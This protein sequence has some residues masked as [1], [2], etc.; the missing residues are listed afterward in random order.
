MRKAKFYESI[1]DFLLAKAGNWLLFDDDIVVVHDGNTT[2]HSAIENGRRADKIDF[3]LEPGPIYLG[4]QE[5]RFGFGV[6]NAKKVH[7]LSWE[8]GESLIAWFW[9]IIV[10]NPTAG[11]FSDPE[12]TL[13][14]NYE[15]VVGTRYNDVLNLWGL[16]PGGA[17]NAAQE[18]RF[19]A[20]QAIAVPLGG[21]PAE[22][23]AM[24]DALMETARQVPQNQQ[25]VV[26]ESGDGNDIVVGTRTGT[27]RIYGGN[28]NDYL[29]AG[30]FTSELYGGPGT[31]YLEGGGFKSQLYGGGGADIFELSSHTFIMDA[32]TD[33]FVTWGG[34]RV[35]GGVQQTWMEAGWAYW[36]P[37]SGLLSGAT[38]PFLGIWGS[39]SVLV[40]IAAA[41][42]FRFALT[43]SNQLVIQYGRGRTGQAVIENYQ[44]NLDTGAAS[45]HVVV[46]AQEI[47]PGRA[48]L[49]DFTRYI[50]LALKAGFGVGL[51]KADPLVVDLDGDGVELVGRGAGVYFDFDRD[52]FAERAAWVHKDDGLLVR[53]R[54]GNGRVDDIGDLFGNANQ[55][56]FTALAA[57]DANHDGRIDRN[58]AAFST[59]RI[60][61]DADQDGV[62]D[63]GELLT[64][65]QAGIE[66]ISLTK[67]A[68]ADAEI[69]GNTVRA[70]ATVTRTDGGV[71]TIADVQ[72]EI[73]QTDSRYLGD[74]TLSPAA[75][76]LPNLKGYGDVADLAVAMM[77]AAVLRQMVATFAALPE[78]AKWGGLKD[79]A[80]D[81]LFRWAGVDGVAATPIAAGLDA[82]KLAFLEKYFGYELTPR[83]SDGVPSPGNA[84]ELVASWQDVLN[85][86]TIR[87]AV[88]GPLALLAH[89]L[90][91]D[92]AAD[93]LFATES[94]DLAA[95]F[96]VAIDALPD[97]AGAAWNQWTGHWA[98]TLIAFTQALVRHDRHEIRIDFAVQSLV[99]AIAQTPSP[100]TL[101]QLADGLGYEGVII[102][103]DA[104][105]TLSR[106]GGDGLRVY[107]G[108]RGNDSIVGGLGQDVYVF[109]RGFGV[110]TIADADAP[111]SLSGDRIRLA[112]HNPGNVAFSRR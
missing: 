73:D 108:G 51:G 60:W 52:G 106:D 44:L 58:D 19:A 15:Y 48:S 97:V 8:P 6:E 40:D 105:E 84:V 26:I 67:R 43:D 70:E 88:Q 4:N 63:A 95:S 41:T 55:S 103:T 71:A 92:V 20:A 35:T 38:L 101:R 57:L 54:N 37:F 90:S 64:L 50:N 39:L 62:T 93:R 56:G 59:L 17:L 33:D 42:T 3:S 23:G 100:L 16:D 32:R 53:D 86:A 99:R 18:A 66:R 9:N 87:L 80:D 72:F 77:G 110:D 82:R 89:G 111:L 34:F 107:V 94:T 78:T 96:R 12:G 69:A 45:G 11:N 46:F 109:G 68:P 5:N 30:G 10:G 25:D 31:D 98:P 85:K 14:T 49:A 21:D 112:L 22:M 74:G 81:I 28:G 13:Y 2:S 102:G 76:A 36:T 1:D 65:V 83:D 91:F 29:F 7:Y 79:R 75:A 61:R 104:A 47:A 27:D 24:L